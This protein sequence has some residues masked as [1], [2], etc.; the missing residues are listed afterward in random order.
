KLDPRARDPWM[1]QGATNATPHFRPQLDD[2]LVDLT[3]CDRRDSRE[4]TSPRR[5]VPGEDFDLVA[6]VGFGVETFEA[7][8]TRRPLDANEDGLVAGEARAAV[9][10]ACAEEVRPE[11]VIETDSSS[12]LD[13]V[14]ADRLAHVRD[15]VDER[16]ARHQEGVGG[17]LDHL[18]RRDV[19]PNDRRIDARVQS[20]D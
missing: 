10:D 3:T 12:D 19:R 4:L 9:A 17:E 11:P 15:L 14:R 18:G 6:F 13:D 8:Q 2:V 1:V 7:D 20:L 16:D 5:R